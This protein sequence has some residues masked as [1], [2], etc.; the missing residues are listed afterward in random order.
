MNANSNILDTF[1]TTVLK[2]GDTSPQTMSGQLIVP[3]I[4]DSGL[5]SSTN[6]ICPGCTVAA[7]PAMKTVTAGTG[8]TVLCAT[9]DTSTYTYNYDI[10]N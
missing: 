8:F 7:A 2:L 5:G 1:S 10:L 3:S 4:I 6:V 9:S